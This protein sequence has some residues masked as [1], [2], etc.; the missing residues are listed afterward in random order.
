MDHLFTVWQTFIL[1]LIK[2]ENL[3]KLHTHFIYTQCSCLWSAKWQFQV[4]YIGINLLLHIHTYITY[5]HLLNSHTYTSM[6]TYLCMYACINMLSWW[7]YILTKNAID[8]LT[9]S[10]KLI[11]LKLTCHVKTITT[12]FNWYLCKSSADTVVGFTRHCNIYFPILFTY[13]WHI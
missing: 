5:I 1:F 6:H 9:K 13:L 8:R 2:A 11:E 10:K 3:W 4:F 12:T 7:G